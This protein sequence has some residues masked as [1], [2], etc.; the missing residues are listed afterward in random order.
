[1]T[2]ERAVTPVIK[3]ADVVMGP[4]VMVGGGIPI[5][6]QA[7][8]VAS[9]AWSKSEVPKAFQSALADVNLDPG[10]QPSVPKA[11]IVEQ[12]NQVAEVAWE[13]TNPA[14]YH[15][16]LGPAQQFFENNM[17]IVSI[18][19]RFNSQPELNAADAIAGAQSVLAQARAVTEVLSSPVIVVN[20][21]SQVE[22]KAKQE[23]VTEE[24][25]L[26]TGEDK[27]DKVNE[28]E[29]EQLE[30]L[31]LRNVEDWQVAQQRRFEI[32]KA[33]EK[34][35]IEAVRSGVKKILGWMVA[36]FL[37][38]Q[39]EGNISQLVRKK[40]LDGSLVD[41]EQAIKN[42]P[43]E[44]K[45]E[46]EAKEGLLSYVALFK[47]AKKAL[48]GEP[49]PKQHVARV[50]KFVKHIFAYEVFVQR[51]IKK[52][53]QVSGQEGITREEEETKVESSLEDYPQLEAVFNG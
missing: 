5:L 21:T 38:G 28:L 41:T 48:K 13:R 50:L 31:W 42:D 23:D 7:E 53:V 24:R 32:K 40:G 45:S 12:A 52:R 29:Q 19:S 35:K 30:Q 36:K 15:T 27:E 25:K 14:P 8:A 22:Q 49:L 44:F 2:I 43:R 4:S 11:D 20:Q 51:I 33:I 26:V 46:Q 10:I 1:M 16:G 9:A 34:A 47:P 39:H 6:Q 37:P 17:N 3:A 18:I